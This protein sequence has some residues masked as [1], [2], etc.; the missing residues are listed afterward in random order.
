MFKLKCTLNT[1]VHNDNHRHCTYSTNKKHTGIHKARRARMSTNGV[2]GSSG[3]MCLGNVIL[4]QTHHEHIACTSTPQARAH[5]ERK[6]TTST[7]TSTPRACLST[8][9][10]A[11]NTSHPQSQ[12]P[13]SL[14]H[15]Y[16]NTICTSR[17]WEYHANTT[18][19]SRARARPHH[20]HN[21]STSTPRAQPQTYYKHTTHTIIPR[22]H[23]WYTTHARIQHGC[24]RTRHIQN[25]I[26]KKL[27]KIM[28]KIIKQKL[29]IRR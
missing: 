24:G 15:N 12:P 14:V 21:T 29:E 10:Y 20:E 26:Q 25:R 28:K 3:E 7:S 13:K 1:H 17:A 18:S 6:H 11:V 23:H 5:H 8:Y 2:D 16:K 19:T 9:K 22:E 27:Q 4:T